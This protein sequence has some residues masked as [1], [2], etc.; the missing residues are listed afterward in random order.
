MIGYFVQEELDGRGKRYAWSLHRIEKGDGAG[1]FAISYINAGSSY[2]T[3]GYIRDTM[4]ARAIAD[5][6]RLAAHDKV[7]F[8][9]VLSG[10]DPPK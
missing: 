2:N 7:P 8:L 10:G 1:T 3:D 6:K 9:G 4:K 5:A